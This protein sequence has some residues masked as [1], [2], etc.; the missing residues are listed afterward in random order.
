M[1]AR[2]SGFGGAFRRMQRLHQ[3]AIVTISA[4]RR[5]MFAAGRPAAIEIRCCF[6]VLTPDAVS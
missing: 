3:G 4:L 1:N 6:K 5:T 2:C